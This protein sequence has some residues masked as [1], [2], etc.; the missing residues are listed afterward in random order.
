[1]YWSPI[2]TG[3]VLRI[4]RGV[5]FGVL[6]LLGCFW[7]MSSDF[8]QAYSSIVPMV[9][10]I[11]GI[12]GAVVFN[13]KMNGPLAATR[14]R[15]ET[16]EIEF[17]IP[18]GKAGSILLKIPN[19]SAKLES[20]GRTMVVF[21]LGREQKRYKMFRY[22]LAHPPDSSNQKFELVLGDDRIDLVPVVSPRE[23]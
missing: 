6:W 22:Y 17:V 23:S 13:L 1:M 7:V 8:G 4:V 2:R 9:G 15:F 12:F 3:K 5:A 18:S 11:L 10:V 14:V 21:R 19:D 20:R 16:N